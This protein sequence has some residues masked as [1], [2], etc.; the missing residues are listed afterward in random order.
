[1]PI[2]QFNGSFPVFGTETGVGLCPTSCWEHQAKYNQ[3]Q[4]QPFLRPKQLCGALR[5]GQLAAQTESN[6]QLRVWRWDRIEPWYEKYNQIANLRGRQSSPLFSQAL[7][8]ASCTQPILVFRPLWRLQGIAIFAPRIGLAYFAQRFRRWPIRQNTWWPR[9]KTSVR[10]SFGMFY[11]RH[12]G[13][14]AWRDE[15]QRSLRITYTSP[16]PPA[17]C[18]SV[19]Y[20]IE[21]PQSGPGFPG[22]ARTS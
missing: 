12:R 21:W 18:H 9:A 10:A 16:A 4:L 11:N 2:A 20:R 14:H 22:H 15:C 3:S 17:L 7:Q 6:A 19:H 5:A 8:P 13:A 1:M